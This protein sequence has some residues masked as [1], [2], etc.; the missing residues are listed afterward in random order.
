MASFG[1]F[2]YFLILF[3]AFLFATAFLR[4]SCDI[5]EES[6]AY[7]IMW[8]GLLLYKKRVTPNQISHIKFKRYGWATKGAVVHT[9]KGFNIRLIDFIPVKL[10]ED[11]G[12]FSDK[13][14][15]PFEKSKDYQ[16]LEKLARDRKKQ[17]SE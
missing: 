5:N 16:I 3:A 4:Y 1:W 12:D 13:H 14:E 8:M 11:L 9:Y 2:S 17:V 10:Y 15:I 7:H 6:I